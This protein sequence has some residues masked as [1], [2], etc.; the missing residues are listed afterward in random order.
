MAMAPWGSRVAIRAP[1]AP[2]LP[3]RR[4]VRTVSLAR[5]PITARLE[6]VTFELAF[7]LDGNPVEVPSA[8]VSWRVRKLKPKGAP[9]VVYSRDGLPLIVPIHATLA[10]LRSAVQLEGRYR[11]DRSTNTGESS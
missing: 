1:R 7:G 9:E 3:R 4:A 6:A 2:P 5:V 11:L 8:A 10:E